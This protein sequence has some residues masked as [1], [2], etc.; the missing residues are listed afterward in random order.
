[1]TEWGQLD[2]LIRTSRCEE[3]RKERWKDEIW[4]GEENRN[5][6]FILL[7]QFHFTIIKHVICVSK[8]EK[9]PFNDLDE[10]THRP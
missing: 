1:M 8:R 9:L 4:V 7:G 6:R 5:E 10:N 2:I 3:K